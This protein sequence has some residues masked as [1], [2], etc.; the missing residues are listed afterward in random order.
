MGRVRVVRWM[1]KKIYTYAILLL[2]I[3]FA[4]LEGFEIFNWV[5]VIIGTLALSSMESIGFCDF[6][7]NIKKHMIITL[8]L[9]PLNFYIT[10]RCYL[11]NDY[12]I[13]VEYLVL[14]LILVISLV[15]F[16]IASFKRGKLDNKEEK[17]SWKGRAISA[18]IAI[19]TLLQIIS[20]IV[21][22]TIANKEVET[23]RIRLEGFHSKYSN[24]SELGDKCDRYQRKEIEKEL[25]KVYNIK[26]CSIADEFII[27]KKKA[28]IGQKKY[29]LFISY[30]D[31][32]NYNWGELFFLK[33]GQVYIKGTNNNYLE[34]KLSGYNEY[35]IITLSNDIK[36]KL[37]E[38]FNKN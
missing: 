10:Y 30:G 5:T 6:E 33:D 4:F 32:N 34:K 13:K 29:S 22:K 35:Y 2:I 19:L 20:P 15:I 3:T 37:D 25:N 24:S 8:I 7:N 17:N 38:I 36:N 21:Y 16:T 28:Q 9:L 26:R 11:T 12:N 27:K 18:I 14:Q 23:K 1:I 31:D